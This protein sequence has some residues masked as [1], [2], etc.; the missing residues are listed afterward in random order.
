MSVT[1]ETPASSRAF[2]L[3]PALPFELRS[4]IW[5]TTLTSR[6][7]E[8]SYD[9]DQGFTTY[10]KLPSALSVSKESR[11]LVLPHYPLCFGGLFSECQIRFNF[12]IDTLYIDS[13]F[14]DNVA[15]FFDIFTTLEITSLRYLALDEMYYDDD[16]DYVPKGLRRIV[17]QLTGTY[18]AHYS[19]FSS[20]CH[21]SAILFR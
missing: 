2:T 10:S 18:L 14:D 15:H 12:A 19:L 13:A 8:V 4:L 1:N 7:V 20:W 16:E 3:F 6:C 11:D 5:K 21:L 17:P 9:E